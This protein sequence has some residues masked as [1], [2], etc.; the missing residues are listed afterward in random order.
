MSLS[1]GCSEVP[2]KKEDPIPYRMESFDTPGGKATE[3]AGE[4]VFEPYY[5]EDFG[6]EHIFDCVVSR[7][8]KCAEEIVAESEKIIETA[9]KRGDEIE[10]EAYEKGFDQGEKDGFELGAKKLDAVLSRIEGIF[11]EMETQKERFVKDNEK[12]ILDL[13]GRVAQRVVHGIVM[14]D[15]EVVRRTILEAFSLISGPAKVTIKVNEEDLE[16]VKELRPAFFERIE[17]VETI[18]ME[19]DP[20]VGRGGCILEASSGNVDARLEK[21][22]DRV[23]EA[24]GANYD[25][26]STAREDPE[27]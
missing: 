17:G 8:G 6:K 2:V 26:L 23:F 4:Y 20:S 25:S 11:N 19:A 16:Y 14:V 24:V 15:K 10:R 7:D 27:S 12:E 13:I 5:E 21:Q 22:L 1:D 3:D 9:K 18:I